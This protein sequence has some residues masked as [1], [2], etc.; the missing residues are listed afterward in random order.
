MLILGIYVFKFM[1]KKVTY[2]YLENSLSK[3][4]NLIKKLLESETYITNTIKASDLI[5]DSINNNNCIFLAGN[6]GS[7]AHSQHFAA[8]LIC[9]F[10]LDRNPLPALALTTDSSVITAISNDYGYENVFEKQIAGLSK[11][12]DVFIGLTTSGTSINVIKAFK[13]A[14]ILNLKT[15]AICGGNGIPSSDFIPDVEIAIPS[16]VT[17]LIQEMHGITTHLICD[18]VEKTIFSEIK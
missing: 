7:A 18:I 3:S 16:K 10:N 1:N 11:K 4:L 9:R 12:G 5:I 8:E 15:I 13:R 6:G 17:S 2:N 14:K